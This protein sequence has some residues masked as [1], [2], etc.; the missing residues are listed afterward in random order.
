MQEES[1]RTFLMRY[2]AM[3]LAASA[4]AIGAAIAADKYLRVLYGPPPTPLPT[5]DPTRPLPSATLYG[6]P[7]SPYATP[8]LQR[9]PPPAPLYGP[10]PRGPSDN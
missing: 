7:P 9:P 6:P 2:A 8:D 1:R 4:A 3:A 10:P 5:F